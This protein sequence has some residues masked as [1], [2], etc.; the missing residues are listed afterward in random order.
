[1]NSF[2]TYKSCVVLLCRTK[3]DELY[4][5]TEDEIRMLKEFENEG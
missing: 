3:K 5:L 1:M 2:D 4:G